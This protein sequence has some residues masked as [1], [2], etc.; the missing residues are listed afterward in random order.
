MSCQTNIGHYLEI[1]QQNFV[2]LAIIIG[3]IDFYHFIPLSVT[4]VLAEGHKVGTKQ[5]LLA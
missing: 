5:D 1:F 4:L 2:I 3:I